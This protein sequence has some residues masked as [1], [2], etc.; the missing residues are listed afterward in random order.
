[1]ETVGP[2]Q[3]YDPL[4]PVD[5]CW[6]NLPHWEQGA[7]TYFITFR[8]ADSLPAAL[9][10]DWRTRRDQWLRAHGLNPPDPD[11]HAGLCRLETAAQRDFHLLFSA[12]LQEYLDAGHGECLLKQ[13]RL[14]RLV[15]DA[16]LFFDGQRYRVGDFVVMPNHVHLLV[17]L[18]GQTSLRAQCR[19][20]KKYSAGQINRA[21]GRHGHFWQGESYD[22]IVRSQEQFEF[23]R[24]YIAENP[25]K[26]GLRE[27]EFVHVPGVARD[28]VRGR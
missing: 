9:C 26:G 22:H 19:S 28:S 23:Y 3:F 27:G 24:Q 16:L 12:R 25:A 4:A 18:L 14:A 17:Q 21:L 2:F 11:W 15:T 5:V 7:V 13:P 6:R 20:W 8:T 1:M 10:S